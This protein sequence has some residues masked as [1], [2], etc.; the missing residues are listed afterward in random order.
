MLVVKR[1]IRWLEGLEG[2]Q[3]QWLVV[4]DELDS[5]KADPSVFIP[6]G[7]QGTLLVTSRR[8]SRSSNVLSYLP[9]DCQ[10]L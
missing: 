9:R 4:I 5:L 8:G 10:T 2:S 1:V 7:K 3:S 6:R